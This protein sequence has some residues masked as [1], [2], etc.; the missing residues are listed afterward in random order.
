M[1]VMV[2]GIAVLEYGNHLPSFHEPP[3][4]FAVRT[5]IPDKEGNDVFVQDSLIPFIPDKNAKVVFNT[6]IHCPQS[7]GRSRSGKRK[8][9]NNCRTPK[10][11]RRWLFTY[12]RNQPLVLF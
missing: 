9:A 7:A 1:S 12:D 8:T 4:W 5:T 10:R 2:N 3:L 6:D 11:L